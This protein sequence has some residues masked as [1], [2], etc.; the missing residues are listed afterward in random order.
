VQTPRRI[1]V[2]HPTCCCLKTGQLRVVSVLATRACVSRFLS[3]QLRDAVRSVF[4]DAMLCRASW[5]FHIKLY[6]G[7]Q[8]VKT[9]QQLLAWCRLRRTEQ[10]QRD[11]T[12]KCL[13]WNPGMY[14]RLVDRVT[15][16]TKGCANG[17]VGHGHTYLAS[18]CDA[19]LAQ[20]PGDRARQKVESNTWP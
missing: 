16:K 9:K 5:L 20:L 6:D 7:E 14:S 2:N 8:W 13:Y 10:Q 12:A 18:F 11:G 4:R 1:C 17:A 19:F 15:P 3:G